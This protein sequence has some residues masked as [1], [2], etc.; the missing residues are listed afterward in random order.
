MVKRVGKGAAPR[1]LGSELIERDELH[2]VVEE[3]IP[4]GEHKEPLAKRFNVIRPR[5]MH[6]WL[7]MQAAQQDA[8]AAAAAEP[9]AACASA[10]AAAIQRAL[11]QWDTVDFIQAKGRAE[12][13]A[14]KIYG[15][16]FANFENFIL[17]VLPQ[18]D[19]DYLLVE[20][21]RAGDPSF[22]APISVNTLVLYFRYLM[23]PEDT[24]LGV[25]SLNLENP[26]PIYCR[27]IGYESLCKAQKAIGYFHRR[28][29]VDSQGVPIPALRHVHHPRV[30]ALFEQSK[31]AN[32]T[33]G[34][35]QF[36]VR[37]CFFHLLLLLA[38]TSSLRY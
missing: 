26:A 19:P 31:L 10:Q 34:A 35:P 11:Q 13:S 24:L 4:Q 2:A 29:C 6:A 22:E 8:A 18:S 3:L 25:S 36:E 23:G 27:G 1:R 30:E 12:K 15:P 37:F 14:H 21:W 7:G 5:L 16:E 20:A 17:S 32:R 33:E 28:A 38:C 9:A